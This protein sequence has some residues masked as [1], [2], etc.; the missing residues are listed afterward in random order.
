[1]RRV[2]FVLIGIVVLVV[3]LFGFGFA[4]LHSGPVRAKIEATLSSAF[5]Q[6]VKL[7]ELKFVLLPTP[8]LGTSGLVAP[9]PTLRQVSR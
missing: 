9:T 4:A 8:T 6:P 5:G 3:V 7:G 1:M 2:V